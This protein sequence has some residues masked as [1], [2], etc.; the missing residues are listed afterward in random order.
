MFSAF[1]NYWYYNRDD[2]YNAIMNQSLLHQIGDYNA[3]MPRSQNRALGNDDQGFWGM[4][5]MSAAENKLPDLK[6][7][8]HSSLSLRPYFRPSTNDGMRRYVVAASSGRSSLQMLDITT[9]TGFQMDASLISPH[10]Y[11]SLL[12][13]VLTLNGPKRRGGGNSL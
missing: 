10:V 4:A 11:T 1:I 3:F 13:T 9:R 5:A 8:P 7:D 12:E 2:Q 6:D